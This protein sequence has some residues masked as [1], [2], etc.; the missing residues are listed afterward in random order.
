[1]IKLTGN[2]ILSTSAFY[3]DNF[4]VEKF[5]NHG[6][7]DIVF[8]NCNIYNCTFISISGTPS[9]KNLKNILHLKL[10]GMSIIL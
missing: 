4:N 3:G 9:P 6:A 7:R 8:T 1:M 10:P 5:I 2:T